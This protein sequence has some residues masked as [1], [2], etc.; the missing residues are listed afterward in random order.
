MEA[1]INI[2]GQAVR[3]KSTAAVPL[4]YRCKFKRDLLQDIQAVADALK[5]KA[6]SGENLPISALTTFERM[7]YIMAK[8]ADPG[9]T[10]DSPEEWLEGFETMSIYGVFPVIEALWAGN[11]DRLEESKKKLGQLTGSLQPPCSCSG[12]C[13]SECR[14]GT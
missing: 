12:P 14:C 6:V 7:A 13:S 5:D 2:D 4:L 10:A 3:F 11:M 9:M 1:T 8:H